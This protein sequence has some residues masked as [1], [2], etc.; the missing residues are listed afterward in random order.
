MPL[1]GCGSPSCLGTTLA[2]CLTVPIVCSSTSLCTGR[3]FSSRRDPLEPAPVGGDPKWCVPLP[4]DPAS[5][6]PPSIS[7][8][9]FRCDMHPNELERCMLFWWWWCVGARFGDTDGEPHGLCNGDLSGLDE[10]EGTWSRRPSSART[11]SPSLWPPRAASP[12]SHAWSEGPPKLGA[13]AV[14]RVGGLCAPQS[15]LPP[16]AASAWEEVWPA[17]SSAPVGPCPPSASLAIVLSPDPTLLRAATIL[18]ARAKIARDRSCAQRVVHGAAL[19][20]HPHR[21]E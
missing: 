10:G 16:P 13:S 11:A 21:L 5:F 14:S 6:S 2:S 3:P 17:S 4:G 18:A 15:K 1:C 19:L 20:V 8:S 7:S 12:T 9:R